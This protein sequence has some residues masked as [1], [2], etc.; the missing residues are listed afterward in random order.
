MREY[1]PEMCDYFPG[2]CRYSPEIRQISRKKIKNGS[3]GV[4]FNPRKA[5]ILN[6]RFAMR[7]S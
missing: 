5:A 7:R 1:S 2:M 3:Q 6:L 4:T